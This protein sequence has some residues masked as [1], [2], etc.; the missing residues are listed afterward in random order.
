MLLRQASRANAFEGEDHNFFKIV[1]S[2]PNSEK[3]FPL[4]RNLIILER[5]GGSLPMNFFFFWIY[6]YILFWNITFYFHITILNII[7]VKLDKK[8]WV[9]F[10]N[11]YIY[12]HVFN[13][14][15]KKK[16]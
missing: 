2:N 13:K 4:N 1:N 8:Y 14:W 7:I 12:I 16:K 10:I 15:I 6:L 11:I 3:K 5:G 9:F